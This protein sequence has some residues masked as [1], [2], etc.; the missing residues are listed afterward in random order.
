MT[1]YSS[2]LQQLNSTTDDIISNSALL[3]SNSYLD[4]V[5]RRADAFKFYDYASIESRRFDSYFTITFEHHVDLMVASIMNLTK[6]Y[7]TT[8]SSFNA[9]DISTLKYNYYKELQPR[10]LAYSRILFDYLQTETGSILT[11]QFRMIILLIAE[12]FVSILFVLYFVWLKTRILRKK[13]E[14]LFLFL[15]IPRA[16]VLNIYKKCDSFLNFCTVV[17]VAY[18]RTSSAR[19]T[20]TRN[21]SLIAHKKRIALKER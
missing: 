16:N 20:V 3:T 4:I 8:T 19:R 21:S 6:F 18:L 10:M 11:T 15:D 1:N 2:I 5:G 17:C 14:I 9:V 13:Q 7:S 12:A